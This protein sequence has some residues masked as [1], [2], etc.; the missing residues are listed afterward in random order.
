MKL[1]FHDP[2]FSFQL[3]RI[4]GQTYYGGADIGECLSTAYRI[5]EGEP[6]SWYA[7][8][9][10]T[11]DRVCQYAEDSDKQGHTISAREAYLR[12]TNY[13][14]NGAAFFLDLDSQDSRINSTWEKGVES[15]KKASKLYS[16]PLEIVEIPY[17][18]TK[19]PGYFYKATSLCKELDDARRPTL[20][21]TTGLDGSQ[22]ELYYLGVAAALRRGYNC[23]TYEGPG[24]GIVIRKQKLPFIHDWEKVVTSTL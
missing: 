4:I 15:F 16:P 12:A 11:A 14:Q 9:L 2:G 19:F 5:K 17:E 22:E 18:G 21:L 20:I 13:Y 24:Q 1:Y 23:I 6:E 8:W 10:R 3:L 7:E